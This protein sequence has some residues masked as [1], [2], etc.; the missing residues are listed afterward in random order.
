MDKEFVIK[1]FVK[2]VH[3]EGVDFSR[4]WH[5]LDLSMMARFKQLALDLHFELKPEQIEAGNTLGYA[6]YEYLQEYVFFTDTPREEIAELKPVEIEGLY[7]EHNGEK[8]TPTTVYF[9]VGNPYDNHRDYGK[10][11]A[12]YNCGLHPVMKS[13]GKRLRNKGL[14]NVCARYDAK[15]GTLHDWYRE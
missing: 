10:A 2:S 6:M 12:M 4:D 3:K 9:G 13:D 14:R 7:F 5:Q 11:F 15:T 8:M 1:S